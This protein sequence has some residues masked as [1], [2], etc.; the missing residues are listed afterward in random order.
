MPFCV[1][2]CKSAASFLAGEGDPRKQ[3]HVCL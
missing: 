3:P 1:V 2:A